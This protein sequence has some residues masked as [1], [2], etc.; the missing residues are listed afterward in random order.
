MMMFAEFLFIPLFRALHDLQELAE[1][2]SASLFDLKKF[3]PCIRS[4]IVEHLT[5]GILSAER[6]AFEMLQYQIIDEDELG[7]KDWFRLHFP[8]SLRMGEITETYQFLRD[9]ETV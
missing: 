7:Q 5:D 8:Q 1:K 4:F 2:A 3:L 6:P 9:C